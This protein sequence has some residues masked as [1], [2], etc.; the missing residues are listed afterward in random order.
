MKSTVPKFMFSCWHAGREA[1]IIH[2]VP[3]LATSYTNRNTWTYGTCDALWSWHKFHYIQMRYSSCGVTTV[4]KAQGYH[5]KTS[6]L[7]WDN[8]LCL[9]TGYSLQDRLSGAPDWSVGAK[10]WAKSS[11]LMWLNCELNLSKAK[12][13]MSNKYMSKYKT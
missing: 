6:D 10:G 11:K 4:T 1:L 12:I 7:E 13:Y 2:K 9:H 8:L 5:G 3:C